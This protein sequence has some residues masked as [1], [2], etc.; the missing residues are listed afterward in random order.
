MG[1]W[2]VPYTPQVP[3]NLAGDGAWGSASDAPLL[4]QCGAE[5]EHL[6]SPQGVQNARGGVCGS[7]AHTHNTHIRT[8]ACM[9]MQTRTH[10]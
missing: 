4:V 1:V 7:N 6:L 10:R 8:D 3:T 2:V 5:H 9:H